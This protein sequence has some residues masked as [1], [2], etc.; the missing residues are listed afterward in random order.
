M[1]QSRAKALELAIIFAAGHPL[2]ND[3]RLFQLAEMFR[4]YLEPPVPT[5]VSDADGDDYPRILVP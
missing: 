1:D 5:P 3:Q 4:E 2:D